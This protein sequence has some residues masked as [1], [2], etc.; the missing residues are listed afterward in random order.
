MALQTKFEEE[1]AEETEQPAQQL[2]RQSPAFQLEAD[3]QPEFDKL[4]VS[5]G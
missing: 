1:V 2:Q 4:C 5:L 3:E